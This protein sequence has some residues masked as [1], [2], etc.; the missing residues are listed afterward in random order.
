ML[1]QLYYPL[2]FEPPCLLTFKKISSLF[3]FSPTQMK[4]F[5]SSLLLLEPTRLLNL[6]KNS[7]LPLLLEPPLVLET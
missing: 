5:P 6:D 2:L 3:V 4:S 1:L 7:R